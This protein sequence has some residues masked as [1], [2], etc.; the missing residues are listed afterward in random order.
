MVVIPIVFMWLCYLGLSLWLAQIFNRWARGEKHRFRYPGVIVML[1]MWL[2]VLWDAPLQEMKYRKLCR[3]EAGL[4]VFK[5]P[6][7]W[8]QE[9]GGLLK[10]L[11]PVEGVVSTTLSKGHSRY[12]LNERFAFDS[13]S[14][15][16]GY[17]LIERRKEVVDLINGEVMIRFVDFDA[18]P[19][20]HI[21]S[22]GRIWLNKPSCRDNK[23]IPRS[24]EILSMRSKFSSMESKFS[25]R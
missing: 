12:F 25:G 17:R 3:E 10:T 19:L 13:V 23:E 20:H 21:P 15:P 2:P 14:T 11:T 6:E 9:H 22:F 5:T 16:I 18:G 1:V 4:T 24:S 7:Q 8:D